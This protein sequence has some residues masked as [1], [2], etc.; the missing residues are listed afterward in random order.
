MDATHILVINAALIAVRFA[1]LW[2]ISIRRKDASFVDSW[3]AVGMVVAAWTTYLVTGDHGP[4][5]V[6]LLAICTIWSLRLGIH[7]FWR[8][9]KNGPHL[10]SSGLTKRGPGDDD[11]RG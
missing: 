2:L 3:W 11:T 1:V 7:L 6:T 9:R 4:H 10:A 5:A 8:W